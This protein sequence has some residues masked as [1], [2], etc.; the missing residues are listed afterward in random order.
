LYYQD[1]PK[2]RV[3]P[4]DSI[5]NFELT[6]CS[7]KLSRACITDCSGFGLCKKRRHENQSTTCTKP[8]LCGS[9][10][11]IR[12]G[13]GIKTQNWY[14]SRCFFFSK[15]SVPVFYCTGTLQK[16]GKRVGGEHA[17]AFATEILIF[18][19]AR[20]NTG[21]FLK[22]TVERLNKKILLINPH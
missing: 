2:K 18:L 14:I 10:D 3:G 7:F 8:Y 9:A 12:Y 20:C 13:T 22:F 21:T 11:A 1:G 6:C 5:I 4:A 15:L 19:L 16:V 17:A